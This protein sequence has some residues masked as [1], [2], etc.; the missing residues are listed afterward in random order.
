MCIYCNTT[1]YRKIFENHY[2]PIPKDE[3]GRSYE[4]HHIDGN[5]KNNLPENLK[6]LSIH[7]HYDIHYAQ[8]DWAACLKI[9]SKMKLTHE[10]LSNIARLSNLRRM[11]RGDHHFLNEEFQNRIHADR[12]K[13]IENGTYHML[14]G[15][16]QSQINAV[17]VK[18]G[19][20]NFL[21]KDAAKKRS[22]DR[23]LNGTHNFLGKNKGTNHSQYDPTIY[24]FENIITGE[25]IRMTKYEFRNTFKGTSVSQL[26]NGK[27]KSTGGWRLIIV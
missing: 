13:R 22:T 8:G 17:R 15:K 7:E 26:I 25:I 19:T 4:I 6:A 1:N 9:G 2:G 12:L 5:R 10:E 16:I 21:D 3:T 24:S 23:V 27:L 14:G 20:H 18:D 11:E